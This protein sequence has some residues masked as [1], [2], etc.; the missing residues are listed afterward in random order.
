MM[1]KRLLHW[2]P[3]MTMVAVVLGAVPLLPATSQLYGQQNLGCGSTPC[4]D[5]TPCA[6]CSGIWLE[7]HGVTWRLLRS[8]GTVTGTAGIDGCLSDQLYTVSGTI[9]NGA[10]SIHAYSP[11]PGGC[12]SVPNNVYLSG[13]LINKSCDIVSSSTGYE[14]NDLGFSGAVSVTYESINAPKTP[15]GETTRGV[16]WGSG[17]DATI[18]QWRQVLTN[19]HSRPADMFNGRQVYESASGTHSDGCIYTGSGD[20]DYGATGGWCNAGADGT[21][22]EWADDYIGLFTTTIDTY[23]N[24]GKTPCSASAGQA[25]NIAKNGSS[26]QT[27]QYATGTI[28]YEIDVEG[29]GTFT[30]IRNGNKVTKAY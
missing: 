6:D 14:T 3:A 9:S 13:T 18:Q 16:G 24:A 8:G 4:L 1:I 17:T 15:S 19:S 20:D 21:D 23:R 27:N 25:M 22:G 5:D 7:S 26:G 28:G 12:G 29:P 11:V 10:V 2:I 30:S